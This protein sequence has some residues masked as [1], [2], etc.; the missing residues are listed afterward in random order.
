MFRC[1]TSS[2]SG[3]AATGVI[4][5]SRELVQ[6]NIIPSQCSSSYALQRLSHIN[7]TNEQELMLTRCDSVANQMPPSQKDNSPPFRFNVLSSHHR[8]DHLTECCER[9]ALVAIIRSLQSWK[10]N[11]SPHPFQDQTEPQLHSSNV[12]TSVMKMS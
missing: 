4:S 10:C 1:L 6:Y 5:S 3:G 9:A 7:L 2:S 11:G 12:Y 8:Q